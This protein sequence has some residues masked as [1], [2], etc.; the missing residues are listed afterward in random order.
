MV[1]DDD[2]SSLHH[3][4][5]FA[6]FRSALCPL[7]LRCCSFTHQI[8][9][10][11][12]TTLS[13]THTCTTLSHRQNIVIYSVVAHNTVSSIELGLIRCA[14]VCHL[15]TFATH[16][17]GS[18]SAWWHR[19]HCT[20]NSVRHDYASVQSICFPS[21]PSSFL[22]SLSHCSHLLHTWKKLTCGILRSFS[23]RFNVPYGGDLVCLPHPRD[24][25]QRPKATVW[26][27]KSS[28][29]AATWICSQK[30]TGWL[31]WG[32]PCRT[33]LF[34]RIFQIAMNQRVFKEILALDWIVNLEDIHAKKDT[35]QKT[36]FDARVSLLERFISQ[37]LY[38]SPF[39][40]LETNITF[41]VSICGVVISC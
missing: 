29:V 18:R 25:V 23:F 27:C 4:V 6:F 7:I 10:D 21:L 24:D 20:H 19:Q 22:N 31:V 5:R 12:H 11:M 28:A 8:V 41:Q 33:F 3:C 9:T 16:L 14:L 17:R 13:H 34:L 30:L 26:L 35:S 15:V 40:G 32:F 2:Y 39:F 38:I 37:S 36:L 1:V